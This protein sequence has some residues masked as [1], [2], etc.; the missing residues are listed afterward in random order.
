MIIKYIFAFCGMKPWFS[1]HDILSSHI[2]Q[3]T[4]GKSIIAG[5]WQP[6]N[7]SMITGRG[8]RN[9]PLVDAVIISVTRNNVIFEAVSW[10]YK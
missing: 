10:Y 1:V 4:I 9:F 3:E 7:I 6:L 2:T 5:L 8:G